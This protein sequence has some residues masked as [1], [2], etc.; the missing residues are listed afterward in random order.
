M[1]TSG[2]RGV[3]GHVM[4]DRYW[5]RDSLDLES[6]EGLEASTSHAIR[7]RQSRSGRYMFQIWSVSTSAEYA[8]QVVALNEF[9]TDITQRLGETIEAQFDAGDTTAAFRFDGAAGVAV[10]FKLLDYHGA[11]S[12]R[13]QLV[14]SRGEQLF[15]VHS[16]AD[17]PRVVLDSHGPFYLLIDRPDAMTSYPPLHFQLSLLPSD[18]E[19]GQN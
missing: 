13:I 10:E 8:F 3:Y 7:L 2:R 18:G 15:K 16:V 17:I 5:L 4:P 14:N 11:A 19:D 1:P 9:A 6:R 12:G